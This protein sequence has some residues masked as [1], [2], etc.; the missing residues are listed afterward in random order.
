MVIYCKT[1]IWGA[2]SV[3]NHINARC[4]NITMGR[5]SQ[6]N[7]IGIYCQ[8]LIIPSYAKYNTFE[9][10]IRYVEL[11]NSTAGSDTK[12]I[13]YYTI[14]HTLSGDSSENK[15]EIPVIRNRLYKTT[16]RNSASVIETITK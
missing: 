12:Y 8:N 10:G 16:V 13:Q 2:V 5:N 6:H 15:R 14:E 3:Y 4:V 11:T 9:S 1:N 7:V